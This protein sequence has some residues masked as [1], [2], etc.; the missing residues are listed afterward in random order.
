MLEVSGGLHFFGGR[1]WRSSHL[2]WWERGVVLDASEIHRS[3]SGDFMCHAIVV[4]DESVVLLRRGTTT[5]PL[6]SRSE[7]RLRSGPINQCGATM[8]KSFSPPEI[9]A[10]LDHTFPQSQTFIRKL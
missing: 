6:S 9:A 7:T 5:S 1:C 2:W 3:C 10:F 8:A 4:S